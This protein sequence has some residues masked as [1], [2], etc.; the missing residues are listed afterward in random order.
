SDGLAIRFHRLVEPP[1]REPAS[2]PGPAHRPHDARPPDL[3]GD[4]SGIDA[5]EDRSEAHAQVGE[6]VRF[7]RAY[8]GSGLANYS[9]FPPF[10]RPHTD[11]C[12]PSAVG[13]RHQ[14]FGRL[15]RGENDG[16]PIAPRASL[17]RLHEYRAAATDLGFH[18]T[19]LRPPSGHEVEV[20]GGV[21]VRIDPVSLSR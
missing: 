9:D 10:R 20:I 3:R 15:F 21:R 1:F 5:V 18:Q 7:A 13:P 2:A 19:H 11:G 6:R 16:H 12:G 4:L 14:P 8:P 17:E